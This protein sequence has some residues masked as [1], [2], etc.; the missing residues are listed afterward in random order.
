MSGSSGP[1]VSS[2]SDSERRYGGTEPRPS[3]SGVGSKVTQPMP[4]KYTSTHACASREVIVR[5]L[6]S[7]YP[8]VNPT[9]TREGMSS[10]RSSTA[11]DDANC[12]QY[13]RLPLNRKS[14]SASRSVAGAVS[15]S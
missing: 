14:A 13:P 6:P 1:T 3:D 8:E 9:A 4:S 2:T 7:R 5:T 12:S 10:V 11:I 15:V